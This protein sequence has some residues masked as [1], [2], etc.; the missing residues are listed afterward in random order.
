LS[1]AGGKLYITDTNN[2]RIL[3]ADLKTKQVNELELKGV[4]PPHSKAQ[5]SVPQRDDIITVK[6]Q[7]V[8]VSDNVTVTVDLSVPNG[9]KLNTLA[10][11]T[12]EV[13]SVDGDPVISSEALEGRDEATAKDG[14]ATFQIPLTGKAGEANVLV[15]VSYGFCRTK[16]GLC[17]LASAAWELPLK[18]VEEGNSPGISLRF[19]AS[20]TKDVGEDDVE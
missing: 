17:R 18:V 7:A 20:K 16:G 13:F 10:P 1:I 15:E 12:W 6:A 8:P 4:A 3:V 5:R 11:V 14:S 9:F 2:H 19:P